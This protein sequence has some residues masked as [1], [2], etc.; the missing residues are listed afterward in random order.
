M[1]MIRLT[2]AHCG[3]LFERVPGHVN[4]SRKKAKRPVPVDVI[5]F[6]EK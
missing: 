3:S 5:T 4:R 6:A 2:C 1:E